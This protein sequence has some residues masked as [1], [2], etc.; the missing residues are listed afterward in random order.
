MSESAFHERHGQYA[1]VA[2]AI[3]YI[4]ANAHRQPP[5]W[6]IAAAVNLSEHHLQRVFA[7]W[8]GISPKRF[9]Q[10]LT[11]EHAKL[12]LQQSADLLGAA[13]SAGLSGP[14]RLHDLMVSSEA[15]SPGEIKAGGKGVALG[16]GLASTPFGDAMIGWTPRGVCY[17]AFCDGDHEE[18]QRELTFQWPAATLV[19]NDREAARLSKRIFPAL[20]MPGRLHLVLRG[21]NFQL[22]VWEAL[23]DTRP[24]QLISYGQLARMAGSPNAQRAVGSAVAANSISYLIPC[25]RVIREGGELGNYRWGSDRKMAIQAWEAA[26]RNDPS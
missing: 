22:K 21:T 5:L 26:R 17:L 1:V 18:R 23:L 16:C 25:H 11:K 15:M 13:L 19:R 12:A 20:P 8:A 7:A 14:G 3:A 2:R 9:L 10:F 4:R 24:S 6:E